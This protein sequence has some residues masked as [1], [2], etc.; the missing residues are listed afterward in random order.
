MYSQNMFENSGQK[1]QQR[2]VFSTREF[3]TKKPCIAAA[4]AH[5]ERPHVGL[6]RWEFK[7]W[8]KY[9]TKP[10]GVAGGSGGWVGV[11][12][13]GLFGRVVF[14]VFCF[15]GFRDSKIWWEKLLV[16]IYN[17]VVLPLGM[18]FEVCVF[19]K[20]VNLEIPGRL[21]S[22]WLVLAWKRFQEQFWSEYNY[23]LE[24]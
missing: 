17:I 19:W 8:I 3:H 24:N 11:G 12:G 20:C 13:L 23:T 10:A 16:S 2:Q 18:G 9:T 14:F 4:A 22:S 1:I 7:L 6:R 15:G 21:A 5:K